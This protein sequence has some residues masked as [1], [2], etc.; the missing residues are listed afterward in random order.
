MDQSRRDPEKYFHTIHEC[1]RNATPSPPPM[2]K[3]RRF[4]EKLG[5]YNIAV[6]FIGTVAIVV[7]LLLLYL[8]WGAVT[9][10]RSYSFPVRWYKVIL[11]GWA[12]RAV[13][14]CSILIR[15]ATAAQLGVFAA[16]LAALILEQVGVATETLPLVSMIRCLNSGPH[17]LAVSIF[18]SIFTNPY[19][20]GNH[21]CLRLAIYFHHVAI[22]FQDHRHCHG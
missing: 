19:R 8:I 9:Y 18:D 17:S 13:T 4:W 2:Q 16:I 22:G 3:P 14:L 7:A 11:L 20:V 5:I 15:V 1:E 12:T 10:A 21:E 6:L